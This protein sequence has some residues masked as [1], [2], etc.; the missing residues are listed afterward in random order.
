MQMLLITSISPL[1][2]V[3]LYTNISVHLSQLNNLKQQFPNSELA[4]SFDYHTMRNCVIDQHKQI[5]GY[6]AT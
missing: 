3:L 5:A 2:K 6:Q 4:R 1:F